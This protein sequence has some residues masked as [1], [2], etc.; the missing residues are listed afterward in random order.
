MSNIYTFIAHIPLFSAE[1]DTR[2]RPMKQPWSSTIVNE[3]TAI[4]PQ[5]NNFLVAQYNGP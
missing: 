4:N 1:M 5:I 3:L 2:K